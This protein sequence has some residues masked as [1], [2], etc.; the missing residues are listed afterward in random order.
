MTFTFQGHFC[1]NIYGILKI[2]DLKVVIWQIS[3][4]NKSKT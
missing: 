2:Q 1:L 3:D 4:E